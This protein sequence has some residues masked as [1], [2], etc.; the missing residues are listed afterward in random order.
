MVLALLCDQ[1][2]RS[3]NIV[4]GSALT[5]SFPQS[6][7]KAKRERETPLKPRDVNKITAWTPPPI[8]GTQTPGAA[9]DHG[10]ARMV[11]F[12]RRAPSTPPAPPLIEKPAR[13]WP[14]AKNASTLWREAQ[15]LV[16]DCGL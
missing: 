11:R 15:A 1:A 9:R 7:Q 16:G 8:G 14:R 6:S 3:A 4:P 5:T 12:Y 13:G 2:R 10:A